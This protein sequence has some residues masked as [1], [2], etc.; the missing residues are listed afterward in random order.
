[1]HIDANGLRYRNSQPG[2]F[3]GIDADG[4]RY[5]FSPSSGVTRYRTVLFGDSMTSQYFPDLSCTASYDADTGVLTV[6]KSAHGLAT[7][8]T[9]DVFNRN[10]GSLLKHRSL[11]LTR[12]DANT[13]TVALPANL[14]GVAT[15]ALTGTT[16]ARRQ[17]AFGSNHWMTW[18]QMRNGWPF[19]VVY[20]GG[21]SGDTT[22]DCLNRL[23]SHCLDYSPHI[24]FM[25][26]PGI[27]DMSSGNGPVQ[28]ETIWA[29][30][31]ELINR[32]LDSGIML[33]LLTTTPVA[34][35]EARGTRTNMA[36]VDLLRRRMKDYLKG[37]GN[38][39]VVDAYSA[40]VSPTDA[41]GLADA[42]KLSTT[43]QIHYQ[44]LGGYSVALAIE[45]ALP[46]LVA[47]KF[48]SLPSSSID[49]WNRSGVSVTIAVTS[50]V[51]TV[52]GTSHGFLVGERPLILGSTTAG[53]NGY[54]TVLTVPTANTF[55]VAAPN[56]VDGAA[57]GT[58]RASLNNNLQ[59][60]PVL[61]TT[62]GG[63]TAN[64]VTGTA[65]DRYSVT[66]FAGNTGTLT[67]VTSV[68]P[69]PDGYGNMQRLTITAAA[70]NDQPG[71]AAEFTSALAADMIAGETYYAEAEIR[72]TSVGNAWEL[73]PINDLR[74][75]VFITVD[76]VTYSIDA[77]S[78]M[79]GLSTVGINKDQVLAVRTP[80]FVMPAG[81]CTTSSIRCWINAQGTF[82]AATLLFDYGREAFRHVD[83]EQNIS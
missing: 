76:A 61:S 42:T 28:V 8:F 79:D 78:S 70:A 74:F 16:F 72:L 20:N 25:Q 69:H 14:S 27:N 63:T 35:G 11:E 57:T 18:L 51:A 2:P 60:E 6:T 68:I 26:A 77:M 80:N 24:V 1:M 62:S 38:A 52:T 4:N 66:N 81:S 48:H 7:G 33:V 23:Q 67:A 17:N 10:Y 46:H 73:H 34:S 36:R 44:V 43:D 31:K 30:L 56:A 58:I 21:Q 64:G 50:G 29:N 49:A 40:I 32:I 82:G 55:T 59:R 9:V 12:T 3:T 13:F 71:F 37:V 22:Q 5:T 19:N 54:R 41:T 83:S 53:L 45:N 47:C 65:A 39:V 15:G 75:Q